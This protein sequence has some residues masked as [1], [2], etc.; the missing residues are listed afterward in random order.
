MFKILLV[1]PGVTE[2]D[3][4]G[5]IQG[6]LDIPLCEDGRRQV[7][8][9]IDELRSQ[10]IAAVY[11]SPSQCAEQTAAAIGEALD[12]KVKSIDKL[13]NLD[14]G[15]WQGMLVADVKAKQPKVYRQ[16]L[17][18]PETVCPPQGETIVA[19]EERLSAAIAKLMK[20][21]KSEGTV[22]IVAPEPLASVLCHVVRHDEYGD[23][24]HSREDAPAWELIEVAPDTVGVK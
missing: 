9:L 11:T 23:L 5:R 4:Q 16:W 21:H 3:Q 8:A 1:R 24:W 14:H 13:D 19:A 2:Y 18:Q 10:P 22:A 12:V 20:K 6:T 7:A 17:E 15:L